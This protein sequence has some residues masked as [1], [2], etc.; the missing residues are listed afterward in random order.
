M[1]SSVVTVPVSVV[2]VPSVVT[3][4]IS[5]VVIASVVTVADRNCYY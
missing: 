4:P 1:V 3:L 5:V 2:V